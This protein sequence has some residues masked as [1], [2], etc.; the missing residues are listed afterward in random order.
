MGTVGDG[1]RDRAEAVW[2]NRQM[3]GQTRSE[4]LAP[5]AATDEAGALFGN[6][7]FGRALMLSSRTVERAKLGRP[8]PAILGR[9]FLVGLAA[10]DADGQRR[11]VRAT[12]IEEKPH[13]IV[14][15]PRQ[16]PP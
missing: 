8:T 6:L 4:A 2:E 1:R 9:P 13:W 3:K 7:Y 15:L 14:L 16:E 12:R 10:L 11:Y 5:R